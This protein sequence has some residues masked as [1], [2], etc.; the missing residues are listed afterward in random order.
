[1]RRNRLL[2]VEQLEDRSTP[3]T[4][5]AG[6]TEQVIATGI[7][8]PSSM[9][10]APDGRVFVA[11]QNGQ[12]KVVQD[13]VVRPTPLF[14]L[15]TRSNGELGLLGFT[16]DPD[17]A[18]NGY[19]YAY[20]RPAVA[21]G[22]VEFNR[23]SRFTTDGSVVLPGTELVLIDLDPILPPGENG[24]HNG[25]AM[26]FGPDG[27][28]YIATG[29]NAHGQLAQSLASTAGKILR[30]NPDGSI[31]DDNPTTFA[32]LAGTPAG[33]Y[34]AIYAVGFRNPFTFD[35]QPGT[36]RIFVNDVGASAFEEIN[37]LLP[38]RN[39]GWPGVEGAGTNPAYTNP[40]YQYAHGAFGTPDFPRAI[41]GGAFYTP[42]A[43]N[44]PARYAGDYFF[45]DFI[46]NFIQTYDP[47]T[48]QVS[49]FA[50]DLTKG[51][52]IDLDTAPNG[53]LYYLARG[54]T[55]LDAGLYRLRFANAPAIAVQPVGVRLN[56]GQ[57][58]TLSVSANGAGPL[59]Y[60]WS[61]DGVAI[62]GATGSTYTVPA[63]SLGDHAASYRVVASNDFGSVESTA[64]VLVVTRSDPPTAAIT[65]P[66]ADPLRPDTNSYV[67]G[68][69][70]TF[71]GVGADPEAGPLPASALTWTVEYHTGAASRP[72]V[73]PTAGGSVTFTIPTATPYTAADVFFRVIL[74]ARDADGH[75]GA[76]YRDLKPV[77]A[78]VTVAASA[79]GVDVLLGG[80]P[81]GRVH[82]YLG[83]A[84]I[85]RT[86]EVP[87]EVTVDGAVWRFVGWFDG[88]T[89]P[90]RTFSTPTT[91][92]TYLAVYERPVE[93]LDGIAAGAGFGGGPVVKTFDA[94]GNLTA[95]RFAFDPAT[96]HGVS[97]ATGDF[98]GDGV[99]DTAAAAGPGGQ[100]VVT[101]TDGATGLTVGTFLAFEP[102]FTGGV[103]VSAAD[104]DG[105]G[106][107]DLILTAGFGG[108]PRVRVVRA[109]NTQVFADFFGID[110]PNFRGGARAAAGDTNGDGQLDLV[111]AAGNTG[112]PRVAG[113]DGRNLLQGQFVRTFADFFA[114]DPALRNGVY[115]SLGDT[116][117]DGRD[118][119]ILGAGFDG[120]PAVRVL[121][122][123]PAG[124]TGAGPETQFFVGD[125]NGRSGVRVLARDLDGDG[126]AEIVTST[127]E[128][129][130][131]VVT[132]TNE[133]GVVLDSWPVLPVALEGGITIG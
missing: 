89:T 112:G 100:P 21:T 58:T 28:L 77:T 61:R 52:V 4:L 26:H 88:V 76:T 90:A 114:F 79:P 51:G 105:D 80:Q 81:V 55:G 109:N 123:T 7:D 75:E 60:Q 120:G 92:T 74:T 25:G 130:P 125:P 16:L 53:D 71:T 72:F 46:A 32:G 83:V 127:G 6:F 13:G 54:E 30:L 86:L 126:R 35:V 97:V 129:Q 121:F 3:T 131:G 41:T 67:S 66:D 2:K 39:Y 70:F 17:F 19:V 49:P 103:N 108:G 84:G 111:V 56:V 38:G 18:T 95:E 96:R 57:S 87:A 82:T 118:D 113:W 62:P 78:N 27:K 69:T 23:V 8:N 65:S 99:P 33:K 15:D 110:D 43:N 128:N 63:V 50:T 22:A 107:D 94:A 124:F 116:N 93:L 98:T 104:F 73:P 106:T 37:E 12:V 44:F 34:R 11:L 9:E 5:P 14:D 119:L 133:A 48:G 102:T 68:Q 59:R 31:P 20:Y 40:V 117:A 101:V 36:G 10:V 122:G 64:A 91:A 47:A 132:V 45:A 29:D 24:T 85:E 42:P 1:M 115:V